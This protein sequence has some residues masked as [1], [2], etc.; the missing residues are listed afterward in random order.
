M[1]LMEYPD[2]KTGRIKKQNYVS[3]LYQAV[4]YDFLNG[5]V[6]LSQAARA[7]GIN[8]SD[9]RRAASYATQLWIDNGTLKFTR[10]IKRKEDF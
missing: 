7:L 3:P 8:P 6:T 10:E 2:V 9:I 5:E 1:R 4:V